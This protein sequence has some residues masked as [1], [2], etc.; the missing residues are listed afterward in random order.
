MQNQALELSSGQALLEQ[1]IFACTTLNPDWADRLVRRDK[2]EAVRRSKRFRVIYKTY[3]NQLFICFFVS[4]IATGE[5]P[6][7]LIDSRRYQA[8]RP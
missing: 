6:G 4:D 8:G 7:T 3:L 1:K 2:E 5:V